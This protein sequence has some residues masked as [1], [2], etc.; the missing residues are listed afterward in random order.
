[1]RRRTEEPLTALYP[2]AQAGHIGF[3]SRF[4]YKNKML[5]VKIG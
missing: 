3:G 1:M 2:A 5:G 4:I